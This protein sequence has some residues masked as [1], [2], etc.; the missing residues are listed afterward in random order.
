MKNYKV[1]TTISDANGNGHCAFAMFDTWAE[2]KAEGE[3]LYARV[4]RHIAPSCHTPIMVRN[5]RSGA[6]YALFVE[7]DGRTFWVRSE[8]PE[9]AM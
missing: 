7:E 3:E 1:Y 2:A 9:S 5:V 4:N 6:S 8:L